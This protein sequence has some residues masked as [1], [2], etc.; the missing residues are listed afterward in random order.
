MKENGKERKNKQQKRNQL[1]DFDGDGDHDALDKWENDLTSDVY[2]LE[3]RV[4]EFIRNTTKPT[5]ASNQSQNQTVQSQHETTQQLQQSVQPEPETSAQKASTSA[6]QAST[7]AVQNMSTQESAQNTQPEATFPGPASFDSWID[8]LK[9]FEE[10]KLASPI[11][12]EL[13][14]ADTLYKLEAGKDIPNIT[15]TKF[16]G[17]PLEYADFID[18]FK[19]HIH[20][21]AHL[22]DDMRMIQ[23]KMHIT[24]DAERSISGLGSKG[25]MYATALKTLKEQ[26]G[27]PS[28][29]ARALINS[30]TKGDRIS[31][32]DR[33]R[34]REFSIDLVNCIATMQ[35]IGYSADINANES[36]RRIIMRLPD[37]LIE[38]WRIVVADIREKG[39]T[40]TVRHICDF[41]R[42]RVK[43]EFDPDFG[44]INRGQRNS[45]QRGVFSAQPDQTGNTLK[46]YVCEEENHRVP[47]CPK[48]TQATI[49]ERLD[50]F[51]KARLCYSCPNRGHSIRDCRAKKKCEKGESCPYSHHPLLHADRTPPPTQA[52]GMASVLDHSSMMP[53]VRARFRAPNGRI[54]EGNIL[55][56]SGAGTTIIRKQFSKALG[57]QGTRERVNLAVVGG[58][59]VE[60]P[61]SRRV[62]FWISSLDSS[63]EFR[64]EA[65]ELE[66]TVLD[67]PEI[68]R[69]RLR[70]FSH[71]RDLEFS[72]KAGP[73]DL[74]LGVHY[75]HLHT[76]TETR[77]GAPFEPVAK[78][79]KLGW[80][81]IGSDGMQNTST[82]CSMSFMKPIDLE[83]FYQFE[84][85]GVQAPPDCSCLK[86]PWSLEDKRAM[87][88]ME[89]SCEHQGNRY[90]I[91]L[92][93]K[94]DKA[95]LPN[96]RVVAENRMR[97]LEKNLLKI[98]EKA[99]MYDAA[100]MQYEEKGWARRLTDMLN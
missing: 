90:M 44:D 3:E 74:I 10:T 31:R 63:E 95:L 23:L 46:C 14:I 66:Q 69:T 52:S 79:T 54:R 61:E 12:A 86:S 36:L 9:E 77:Q 65:H 84:T 51:Q 58:K 15:L 32:N 37:H 100:I 78:K 7:S 73:I 60:Q 29:I 43:A 99:Q 71:L 76:E 68:D 28:V 2:G 1:Y 88:L 11:T 35:R 42:K 59:K 91:S 13:S 4:E 19:I 39:Q 80:F 34:L 56:D 20:D 97:S 57:L 70:S 33:E 26:F 8:K 38:R 62:G 18:R 81:V 67:V 40:P 87:E 92:P 72:H 94:K 25:I 93:W 64:I 21:K 5:L 89:S 55:V 82:V 98:N 45:D 83:K 16:N 24:G 22:T 17:N 47:E 27:Q 53:V 75:S 85:L 50:L 49:R 6:Q 41:V 48:V 96:N 30:V